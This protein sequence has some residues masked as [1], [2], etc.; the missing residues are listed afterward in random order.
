MTKSS[1]VDASS[2]EAAEGRGLFYPGGRTGVLL[3][4]GLSGTPVEMRFIANGLAREGYTVSCPQLAGHC[5]TLEQLRAST[6][7][8]W[9]GSTEQALLQLSERCDQVFVAGLSMGGLLSLRLAALHPDK[10]KGAMVYAPTLWLDGWGVPL[11]AKLFSLVRQKWAADLMH[12]TERPP[13][14][15]KDHR[16]RALIAEALHSGDPSKAGFFSIPGG[17]MIELRWLV[18]DLR[19]RLA[20]VKQPVLLLH[21]REDDRASLRNS[22][23]LQKHLGGR[24]ETI[25]L[26]DSY[27]VV[28]LDKQR[29]VV[30]QKSVSFVQALLAQMP[31]VEP[32]TARRGIAAA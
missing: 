26:E 1:E 31:A 24:V 15:I 32:A 5:E 11:Y 4:H 23:Y 3:I 21:P 16:L 7:Q 8:D 22:T 28:T 13:Y 17:P 14:G 25:V 19:K 2:A 6:W 30:L 27:H 29:D 9:Y 12:F 20:D 18:D 10:V